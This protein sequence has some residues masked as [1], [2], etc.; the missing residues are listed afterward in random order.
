MS[1]D[2]ALSPAPALTHSKADTRVA[3]SACL[4]C[5]HLAPCLS[6]SAVAASCICP[7]EGRQWARSEHAG[8]PVQQRTLPGSNNA[9]Q[10]SPRVPKDL[11][12]PFRRRRLVAFRRGGAIA[13]PLCMDRL[14][15]GLGLYYY[16]HGHSAG[17][18]NSEWLMRK[19][20]LP[21]SGALPYLT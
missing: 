8:F 20:R 14:H 13:C 2:H 6:Y 12:T 18:N 11:L 9:K 3:V 5:R 19:A 7:S 4:Q 10:G 15:S 17:G 1:T 16:S 21:L